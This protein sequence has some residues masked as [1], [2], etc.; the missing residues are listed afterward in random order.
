MSNVRVNDWPLCENTTGSSSNQRPAVA[1]PWSR[2]MPKPWSTPGATPAPLPESGVA[3]P[4]S[5]ALTIAA[6]G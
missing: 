6:D 4:T 5:I 3:P 1:A 2:A